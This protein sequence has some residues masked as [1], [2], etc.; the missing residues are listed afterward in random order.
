MINTLLTLYAP[1]DIPLYIE[2]ETLYYCTTLTRTSFYITF[3]EEEPIIYTLS[4]KDSFQ[5]TYV[6]L[7]EEENPC[8]TIIMEILLYY[9]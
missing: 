9:F 5:H 8:S 1:F 6:S 4:D 7:G 3:N 2:K